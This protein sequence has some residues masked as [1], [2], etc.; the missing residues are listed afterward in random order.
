MPR[1]LLAVLLAACSDTCPAPY[2][3]EDQVEVWFRSG[4]TQTTV[5]TINAEIG[6]G[7]LSSQELGTDVVYQ[8]ELPRGVDVDEARAFYMTKPE[9]SQATWIISHAC[10]A[11]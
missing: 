2:L 10:P 11:G 4:T 5:E 8:I 6:A 9:V 1:A 7:I 3:V